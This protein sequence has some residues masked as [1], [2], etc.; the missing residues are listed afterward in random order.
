VSTTRAQLT[1]LSLVC[2]G[3]VTIDVCNA[4]LPVFQSVESLAESI[5]MF[6]YLTDD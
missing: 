6:E 2:G 3:D 5:Q 1:T 4:G